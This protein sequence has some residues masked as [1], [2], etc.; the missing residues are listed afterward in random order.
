MNGDMM[1]KIYKEYL[2]TQA[3]LKVF[4][5]SAETKYASK[6]LCHQCYEFYSKLSKKLLNK[7]GSISQLALMQLGDPYYEKNRRMVEKAY[8]L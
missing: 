2:N 7:D 1:E 8:K 4:S 5:S 6:E 3:G